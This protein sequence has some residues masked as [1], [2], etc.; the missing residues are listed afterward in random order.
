MSD[1]GNLSVFYG[2]DLNK[3]VVNENFNSPFCFA[4]HEW[5]SV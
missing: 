2:E 5:F 3:F 1:Q 4:L